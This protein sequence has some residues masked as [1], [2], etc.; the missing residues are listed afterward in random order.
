MEYISQGKQIHRTITD[1]SALASVDNIVTLPGRFLLV[2][3]AGYFRRVWKFRT[4]TTAKKQWS[5]ENSYYY[6]RNIT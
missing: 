1:N 2:T 3:G 6:M 5:V 4:R